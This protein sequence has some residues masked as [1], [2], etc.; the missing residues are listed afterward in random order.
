MKGL[1]VNCMGKK[2][3]AHVLVKKGLT[4]DLKSHVCWHVYGLLYRSEKN[5]DKA[6]QCYKSALKNDPVSYDLPK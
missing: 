1:V 6:I 3:E 4:N 2:D 5:Y